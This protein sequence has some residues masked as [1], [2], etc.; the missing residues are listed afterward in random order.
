MYHGKEIMKLLFPISGF[1]GIYSKD[2]THAYLD[3]SDVGSIAG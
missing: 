1:D 3:L 2:S